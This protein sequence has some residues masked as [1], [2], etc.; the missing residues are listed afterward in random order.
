VGVMDASGPG[1]LRRRDPQ[2]R[3]AG[4]DVMVVRGG[5]SLAAGEWSRWTKL[6]ASNFDLSPRSVGGA[7]PVAL[8]RIP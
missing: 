7:N 1:G 6:L 2:P 8:T 5:E 3:R 4:A